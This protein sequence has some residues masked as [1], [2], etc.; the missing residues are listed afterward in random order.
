M[1]PR[2]AACVVA[3]VAAAAPLL[4]PRHSGAAPAGPTAPATRPAAAAAAAVPP[5]L[6]EATSSFG[7]VACDGW[8]YV[9]GG[10]VTPTHE[11]HAAAVS[12]RFF[13][14]KLAGGAAWEELPGGPGLQGMNL[15]AHGGKVYRVGGMRPR[16]KK[17]EPADMVSVADCA[18]FNPATRKWEPLPPLPEP[19]SS[20]DVA[21][22]GDTL[23]A[24]GGWTMKGKDGDSEWLGHMAA[25]DLSARPL[26]WKTVKQPF[27]RRALTTAVRRGKLYV[28]GGFTDEA[29]PSRR[30][31]VYDPAAGRWSAGPDLPDK[32]LAGFSPAACTAGDDLLVGIA[33]GTIYRLDEQAGTWAP[34]GANAPRIV[35]RMVADGDRVVVLGG[36]RKGNM[37]DSVEAIDLRR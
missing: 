4:V 29:D 13:R 5:K 30:V 7:A 9:Y 25:L 12:G 32:P 35:H 14:L 6:P 8:A 28:V 36:S 3:V 26:A 24:V 11:Y 22:V 37:L 21:V 10:H 15:A 20:H 33:D 1:S 16:N 27:E 23:L 2:L 34:A 18:A 17:G 31:D 19:R